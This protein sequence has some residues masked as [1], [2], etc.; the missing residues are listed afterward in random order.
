MAAPDYRHE[1]EKL[2]DIRQ[3]GAQGAL[4]EKEQD[5]KIS[6]RH[7]PPRQ[8]SIASLFCELILI[9]NEKG[10]TDPAR[11]YFLLKNT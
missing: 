4:S 5:D 3:P 11:V 2:A 6:L 8:G 10:G 7:N 9:E 1:P